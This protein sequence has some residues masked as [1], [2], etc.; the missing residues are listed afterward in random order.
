MASVPDSASV[1]SAGRER[2]IEN[3]D[4]LRRLK[5]ARNRK[6][7]SISLQEGVHCELDHDV[8]LAVD[9]EIA[10]QEQIAEEI[11]RA[12]EP[13]VDTTSSQDETA[14]LSS[15]TPGASHVATFEQLGQLAR[16]NS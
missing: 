10:R 16:S 13:G 11:E 15:E 4:E 3:T 9:V 6:F 14:A 2:G 5:N 8:E 12:S 7:E 1:P